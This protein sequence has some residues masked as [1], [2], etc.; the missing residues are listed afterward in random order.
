MNYMKQFFDLYS[1]KNI[2]LKREIV[3]D[4]I[5][6]IIINRQISGIDEFNQMTQKLRTA[7]QISSSEILNIYYKYATIY[8]VNNDITRFYECN[9]GDLIEKIV[10]TWRQTRN[11]YKNK[12]LKVKV[13]KYHMNSN[14]RIVDELIVLAILDCKQVENASKFC[15]NNEVIASTVNLELKF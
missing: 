13:I 2:K 10:L 4:I 1:E 11:I 5:K 14:W 8:S 9:N 6:N 7:S 12:Y 15:R 3:E